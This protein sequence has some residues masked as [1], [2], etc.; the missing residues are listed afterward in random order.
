MTVHCAARDGLDTL[1]KEHGPA[2]RLSLHALARAEACERNCSLR[3]AGRSGHAP[4]G[5]R[6]CL[7]RGVAGQKFRPPFQ[8]RQ[9]PKTAVFGRSPQR[10]KAFPEKRIL[11]VN[12]AASQWDT[13]PEGLFCKRKEPL[14]L[15]FRGG[16]PQE[17][18]QA[19]V[20]TR[21]ASGGGVPSSNDKKRRND[22]WHLAEEALRRRT[23]C[24]RGPTSILS[25]RP[26]PRQC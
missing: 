24:C 18:R 25:A 8:R 19:I 3:G 22:R 5:A 7:L 15:P 16:L 17:R 11:R 4:K 20:R 10:A 1:P 14:C 21:G 6:S 13:A 23:R 2:G 12:G 9:I 26:A